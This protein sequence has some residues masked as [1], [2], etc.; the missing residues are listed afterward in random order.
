MSASFDYAFSQEYQ[1]KDKLLE[2]FDAL[3]ALERKRKKE[4][5]IK[6]ERVFHDWAAVVEVTEHALAVETENGQTVAPIVINPEI[7]RLIFVGDDL[8]FKAGFFAGQWHV[9]F[10]QAIGGSMGSSLH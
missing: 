1:R 3:E 4:K 9:I 10:I 5:K 2:L 8:F 7:S 6:Y